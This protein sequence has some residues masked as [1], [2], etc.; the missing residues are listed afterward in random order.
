MVLDADLT[1][2]QAYK[3]SIPA[4]VDT[5][6]EAICEPLVDLLTMALVKPSA[7]NAT[8]PTL[9]PCV[10]IAGYVP[11]PAVVSHRQKHLLY[12]NLPS[13]I[14]AS[15]TSPYSDPALVDVARG[16]HNMVTEA[17]LDRNNRS[18]AREVARHPRTAR[19]RLG[20]AFTDCLLLM[21]RTDDDDDLSQVYHEWAAR[22]LV[23]RNGTLCSRVWTLPRPSST[24]RVLR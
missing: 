12:R 5:G 21:C 10:G 3:L 20:D 22:P 11:S 7:E 19:E 23:Y 14:P 24:Y 1:A 18:D 4:L 9:Q 2:R 16:M 13:L 17:R 6:Y 8:P 15:A